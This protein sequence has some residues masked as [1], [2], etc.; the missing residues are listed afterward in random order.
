M[1][2]NIILSSYNKYIVLRDQIRKCLLVT[3][4]DIINNTTF[5]IPFDINIIIKKAQQYKMG[6]PLSN[7]KIFEYIE[8]LVNTLPKLYYNL[9]NDKIFDNPLYKIKID[10]TKLIEFIIR[11]NLMPTKISPITESQM[12]FICTQILNLYR[13]AI[14]EPGTMVGVTSSYFIAEPIMQF[15]LDSFHNI[16][17]AK[18]SMI[19]ISPMEAIQEKMNMTKNVS[20]PTMQ[21]YPYDIDNNIE[22]IK[23]IS[24]QIENVT[25]DTLIIEYQIVIDNEISKTESIISEDINF[26][27][28][29]KNLYST[30]IPKDL[31]KT[32]IRILIS[33]EK[34]LEKNILMGEIATA[35]ES[36]F[37][38]VYCVYSTVNHDIFVIRVYFRTGNLEKIREIDKIKEIYEELKKK[39]ISVRGIDKIIG[40]SVSVETG[41]KILDDGSITTFDQ[42]YIVTL[43]SNLHEILKLNHLI[44][45]NRV[46]TN[47]I[48]EIYTEL[49]Y[50]ALYRHLC[51]EIM[52]IFYGAGQS[53]SEKHIELLVDNICHNYVFTQTNRFGFAKS[54]FPPWSK[55]SFE[56]PMEF[57][58]EAAL[59]SETDDLKCFDSTL[60]ASKQFFGGTNYSKIVLN[61][62]KII[63]LL[64][65]SYDVKTEDIVEDLGF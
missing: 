5:H 30:L 22:A 39:K 28:D 37:K 64:S 17:K 46:Y 24:Y 6:K 54:D 38:G 12:S 9:N 18:K 60:V 16:G 32:F 45:V 13:G 34:L 63:E 51:D 7:I 31:S 21:I 44:D 25:L 23:N 50:E 33:K 41:T 48:N 26:I 29:Y 11:A 1:S 35:I 27:N 10:S 59:Y 53:I 4:K 57:M 52:N 42:H 62:D 56:T 58:N 19:D 55:I 61:E 47:D 40:L 43:G 65:E 3:N 2:D 15:T 14:V 36:F 49:G 20:V 8:D